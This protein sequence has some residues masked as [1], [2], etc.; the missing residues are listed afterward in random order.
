MATTVIP[1]PNW[2]MIDYYPKKSGIK[3]YDSRTL[4]FMKMGQVFDQ[5]RQVIFE[6]RVKEWLKHYISYYFPGETVVLAVAPGHL[7]YNNSSFMYRLIGE[8]ILENFLQLCLEDGRSLLVRCKTIEKQSDAGANR[9][10]TT[11]RESICIHLSC[12]PPP[13]PHLP[14]EGKVVIILDDI[15]TSGCTLRV[16]EEKVRTTGPKNV[17]VLAIGKTV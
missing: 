1:A 8:F 3:H 12:P 10:E 2:Y 16:C 14:N 13:P 17:R 9:N 4:I 15:Y 5:S 11:H 6:S 7:E